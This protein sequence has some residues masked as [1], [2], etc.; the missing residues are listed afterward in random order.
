MFNTIRTVIEPAQTRCSRRRYGACWPLWAA[1]LAAVVS[2]LAL[3]V[4]PRAG[5]PVAAYYL[6]DRNRAFA[7]AAQAGAD[8]IL[9]D[10]GLGGMVIARSDLP[11]FGSRLLASGALIALRAPALTECMRKD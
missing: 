10:G 7:G 5:E 11:D 3:T 4:W 6:G 9:G 1:M 8:S 2:P